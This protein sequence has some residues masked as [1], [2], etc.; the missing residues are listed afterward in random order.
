MQAILKDIEKK[1]QVIQKAMDSTNNPQ[2]KAMFEHCLQNAAQVLANFKEIDRI[3][4]SRED[5]TKE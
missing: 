3:V 4:N 2:Q 1:M 5:G